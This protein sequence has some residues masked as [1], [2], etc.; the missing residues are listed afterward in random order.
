MALTTKEGQDLKF[1]VNGK[2]VGEKE[3]KEWLSSFMPDQPK[4]IDLMMD[5]LRKVAQDVKSDM[6]ADG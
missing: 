3:Y 1:E 6:S 5:K 2:I 4:S